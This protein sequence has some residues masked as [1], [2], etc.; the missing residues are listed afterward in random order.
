VESETEAAASCCSE[1][2]MGVKLTRDC[3]ATC[4]VHVRQAS[5]EALVAPVL[6]AAGF[7][8]P[9]Q[10]E[11]C[12]GWNRN[13]TTTVRGDVWC[14]PS[15]ALTATVTLHL[16]SASTASNMESDRADKQ[17]LSLKIGMQEVT[18]FCSCRELNAQIVLSCLVSVAIATVQIQLT[19]GFA[20]DIQRHVEG[21]RIQRLLILLSSG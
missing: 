18:C 4:T 17:K 2:E 8:V 9:F 12:E 16:P 20:A 15:V 1:I 6:A 11:S 5:V 3:A 14:L 13:L 7:G 21:E 10:A 19:A